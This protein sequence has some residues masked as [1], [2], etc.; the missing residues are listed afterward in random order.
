MEKWARN[1]HTVFLEENAV[2]HHET[3]VSERIQVFER[4]ASDC[5]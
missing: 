1:H 5:D 4:V 3:D 2:L